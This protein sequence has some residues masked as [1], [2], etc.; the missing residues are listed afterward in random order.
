MK[1]R[2]A[3]II[4][5]RVSKTFRE[6]GLTLPVSNLHV[7]EPVPLLRQRHQALHQKMQARRPDRELVGLRAEQASLDADPVAEIKQLVDREIERRQ[8]VLPDVDLNLRA[9]V[10]EHQEIGLPERADREDAP[11]R[12]GFNPVAFELVVGAPA[13]GLD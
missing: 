3:A 1:S 4:L 6:S 12:G 10:R 8:R 2:T 9:A 11:A 13:V 5:L 7:R